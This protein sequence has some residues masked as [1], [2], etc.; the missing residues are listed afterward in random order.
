[1]CTL[2]VA[3]RKC[4]EGKGTKVEGKRDEGQ[5]VA[6]TRMHRNFDANKERTDRQVGE[7][8]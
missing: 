3:Q 8:V 7:G 2:L 4:G 1:M 5:C 6:V